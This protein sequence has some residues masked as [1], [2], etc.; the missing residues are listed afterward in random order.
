MAL[1]ALGLLQQGLDTLRGLQG[2]ELAEQNKLQNSL[3]DQT[4]GQ[5]SA[6][7][8]SRPVINDL[9][10]VPKNFLTDTDET[11]DNGHSSALTPSEAVQRTLG[12]ALDSIIG[13]LAEVFERLGNSK[14]AA[15]DF[16]QNLVN[17]I[18]SAAGNSDEFSFSF[19]QAVS[20]SSRTAISYSGADGSASGVSEQAYMAV[21]SLDIYVNNNTGELSFN[22]TS[23]QAEVTRTT[24]VASSNSAAGAND[25]L[26]KVMQGLEG[27]TLL[28]AGEGL[29]LDDLKPKLGDLVSRLIGNRP[30]DK[31][32]E[33]KN[34]LE[35]L[36]KNGPLLILRDREEIVPKK[37][38]DD[39]ITRLRT[40][41]LIPIGQLFNGSRGLEFEGKDSVR[42]LLVDT[43]A[44]GLSKVDLDA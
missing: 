36:F 32:E 13:T 9:V 44:N 25:L 35:P 24:G 39:S 5:K 26:G 42:Q 31:N 40:D 3:A 17:S 33:N 37:D 21:Q 11:N 19:E 14:E 8:F 34:V 29:L 38:D 23:V 6:G 15:L 22:F 27:G 4:E 41:L 16:A 10:D 1:S 30:H 7:R 28:E 20:S 12:A 43:F 2:R 18:K